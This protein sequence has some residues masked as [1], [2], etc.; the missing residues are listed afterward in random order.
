MEFNQP[1]GPGDENFW[2]DNI[3]EMDRLR[4]V[5]AICNQ[6]NDFFDIKLLRSLVKEYYALRIENAWWKAMGYEEG[7]LEIMR[8][9]QRE[10]IK[11]RFKLAFAEAQKQEATDFL[12]DGRVYKTGMPEKSDQ[13]MM[14]EETAKETAKKLNINFNRE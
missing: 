6:D 3:D 1:L 14:K 4:L 8:L 2:H 12:F 7:R 10:L 5:D 11:S 13:D 9:K